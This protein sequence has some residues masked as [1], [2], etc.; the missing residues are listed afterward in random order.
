[1]SQLWAEAP[2]VALAIY[3]HPADADVACGA[4]LARWAKAGAAVHVVVCTSG[5]KGTLEA[6]VEPGQL[7]TRRAGE[8]AAAGSVLGVSSQHLL[9]VADGEVDD[10]PGLRGRLVELIRRFRPD[11]VV[12]PDPEALIFGSAYVNHRD[13]RMVG[14]VAL[15]AVAPAA[16][17][18]GYF[19]RSGPPHQVRTVLLSATL[20]PDC[21]VDVSETLAAKIETVSCHASQVGDAQ[22]VAPVL[23]RR[24]EEE[25]RAGGALRAEGFRRVTLSR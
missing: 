20:H 23:S 3:A 22:W 17:M 2:E 4:T 7:V 13:H 10:G 16:A 5:D 6:G 21:W 9:A 19:G 24:A 14:W 18:P 1:M 15:D 25:G 8:V 12:C 11:V